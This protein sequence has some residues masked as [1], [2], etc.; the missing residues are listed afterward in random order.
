[1][2]SISLCM[3]VKNE[4]KTLGRCL[5][6]IKDIVDE[7]N[8]IDTGSTDKTKEIAL[9]YTDR[10]YDF[11]WCDD[12][13]KARNFSF[14][15]ATKE[16]IMWL[17]ADDVILP[18]DREKLKKLKE[19]LDKTID[20]VMF[21]YNLNLD[22]NGVPALS[23]NRERLLKRDKKYIWKS[24]IHE[25]IELTGK[26][27]YMDIAVTHKKEANNNPKRNLNIFENMLKKGIKLDARQTFYYAREL[28]YNEEYEKAEKYFLE[29]MQDEKGF[30]ENKIS[31]C[32][33]MYQLYLKLS[34]EEKAIQSLFKSF[35]YDTPRAEVCCNIAAFL[36]NKEKYEAAIYWY[37][38][39]GQKTFNVNSAGF[40][41]KDCYD[42]I[43]Y[44]G[45]CVCYFKLG[46]LV[47]SNKYNELAG[48]IKPNDTTYI[49]N[50]KYFK[51]LGIKK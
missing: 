10:V 43:P 49:N 20:I 51:N 36:F 47:N 48:K 40:Y 34:K 7:I 25:A 23:Y 41:I 14:S 8:I 16:Y 37:N 4:E 3:I 26:I 5:D 19:N 27:E 17:D 35:L 42:Y 13:A 39:A 22:E 6:S 9:S 1:M 45:L 21:K 12:F 28:Y 31:A 18:K 24:P 29:F 15:K 32:L 46:D 38:Q 30:V 2:I 11:K 50:A 33:D 44:I